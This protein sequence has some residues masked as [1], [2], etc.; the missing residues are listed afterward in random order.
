[1]RGESEPR[2][3]PGSRERDTRMEVPDSFALAG[4]GFRDDGWK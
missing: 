4:L 3:D 1:M 2:S